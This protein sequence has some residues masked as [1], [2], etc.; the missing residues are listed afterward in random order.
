MGHTAVLWNVKENYGRHDTL[1][2]KVCH[3]FILV[4][5]KHLQGFRWDDGGNQPS[6]CAGCQCSASE[7]SRLMNTPNLTWSRV[8]A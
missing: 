7:K 4:D 1:L 6:V 5:V 3:R 8:Q 2:L